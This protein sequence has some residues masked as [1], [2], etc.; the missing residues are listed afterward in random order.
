M[1]TIHRHDSVPECPAPAR[2]PY[3]LSAP[4]VHLL[5]GV[6][7]GGGVV[8]RLVQQ[9]VVA[10][11]ARL[12]QQILL[13]SALPESRVPQ[14]LDVDVLHLPLQLL[15]AAGEVRA[16]TLLHVVTDLQICCSPLDAVFM[17]R[18]QIVQWIANL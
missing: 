4:V 15:Q 2:A 12:P 7:A 8:V 13:V 16:E 3:P 17:S 9:V 11:V 1:L 18:L 14:P 6:A 5:E 10:G